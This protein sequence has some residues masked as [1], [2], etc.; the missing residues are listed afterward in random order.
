MYQQK[1]QQPKKPENTSRML[2]GTDVNKCLPIPA[3]F[4]LKKSLILAKIF[5]F[6]RVYVQFT[7]EQYI[8]TTQLVGFATTRFQGGRK[9]YLSYVPPFFWTMCLVLQ[10]YFAVRGGQKNVSQWAIHG[11]NKSEALII[12]TSSY[13]LIV[14]SE[15]TCPSRSQLQSV[16]ENRPG[17]PSSQLHLFVVCKT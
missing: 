15:Q 16:G 12:I 13:S 2:R 4:Y 6:L 3:K 8:K 10:V 1:K 17:A 7:S 9:K 11:Q 14:A 5:H